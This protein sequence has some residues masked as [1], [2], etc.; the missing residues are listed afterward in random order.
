MEIT[1]QPKIDIV[2]AEKQ[3]VPDVAR[4][5]FEAFGEFYK[6]KDE[7]LADVEQKQKDGTLWVAIVDGK[8]IGTFGYV[9][10]WSHGAN[11]LEGIVV[12][13]EYRRSGIGSKL[14]ERFI[15][16]CREE[17]TNQP[18][19]L[20]STSVDNAASISV[21]RKMG[22]EECGI[23]KGLHYGKDEIL[24]RLRVK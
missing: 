2:K 20:S 24:F 22:F 5:Y 1:Q 21:H 13:A 15:Q 7:A 17:Q 16:V 8:V 23:M 10:E 14:L 19:A 3:H 9:R 6:S 11:Y 12:D 18:Y 4:L